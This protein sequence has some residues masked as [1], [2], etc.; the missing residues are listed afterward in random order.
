MGWNI[1]LYLI[2]FLFFIDIIVCF[3]SALQDDDFKTI[4]DRKVIALEYISGWFLLDLFAILPL[5]EI[6]MAFSE[7]G[8]GGASPDNLN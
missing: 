6:M 5:S 4:D 1:A 2:D 3:N 8:G 7:S